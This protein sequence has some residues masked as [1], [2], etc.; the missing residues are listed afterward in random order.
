MRAIAVTGAETLVPAARHAHRRGA[1]LSQVRSE[2]LAGVV[3]PQGTPRTLIDLINGEAVKALRSPDVASRIAAQ[4]FEVIGDT[5]AQAA[6]FLDAE[7]AKW[8]EAVKF[9]GAQPD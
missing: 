9:S 2:H 6:Q 3:S 5:P 4:G 7:I 8:G 1:G